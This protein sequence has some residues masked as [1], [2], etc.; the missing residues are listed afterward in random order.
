MLNNLSDKNSISNI[1]AQN[2]R[3]EFN[4]KVANQDYIDINLINFYI[5]EIK[6]LLEERENKNL[7]TYFVRH[8]QTD[9]NLDKKMNPGDV[10]SVLNSTWIDDS[11][12][13]WVLCVENKIN[14]DV[15]ISSWLSRTK[16]TGEIIWNQIEETQWTK[17]KYLEDTLLKEMFAWTLKDLSHEELY[18]ISW[19]KNSTELRVW[20]KNI[21]NNWIESLE[22]FELRVM[23][24]IYKTLLDNKEKNIMYVGHSGTSRVYKRIIEWHSIEKTHYN[25]DSV[26]NSLVFELELL[27]QKFSSILD[28][29]AA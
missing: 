4:Q 22:Y 2:I 24:G 26:P 10:D 6:W 18:K 5:D 27:N 9:R 14:V 20:Y 11:T 12:E 16:Q 7:S 1:I 29:E 13:M 28:K 21:Q 25:L 19:A 23:I 3:E 17:I 15:I 8:G